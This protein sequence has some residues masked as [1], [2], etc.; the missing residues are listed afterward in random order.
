MLE[1]IITANFIAHF[2]FASIN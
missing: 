2:T 1:I